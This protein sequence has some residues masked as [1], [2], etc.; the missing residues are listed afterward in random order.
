MNNI[1]YITT[2]IRNLKTRELVALI[3]LKINKGEIEFNKS[4][5]EVLYQA[6]LF[7]NRGKVIICDWTYFYFDKD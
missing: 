1:N 4:T 5:V 2:N 6:L 7:I 3:N